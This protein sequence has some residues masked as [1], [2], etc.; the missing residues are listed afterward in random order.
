MAQ[1]ARG[2]FLQ[3]LAIQRRVIA[4]LV[5]RELYARYGRDNLGFLWLML[6]PLM[7]AAGVIVLFRG[8]RGPFENNLPVVPIVFLGYLPLLLYRHTIGRCLRCVRRNSGLLYHRQVTTLD[9]V[10]TEIVVEFA[11]NMLALVTTFTALFTL[12]LIDWPA[13]LATF[14]LGYGLM[15]WFAV[16]TALTLGALSE[17]SE[18]VERLWIPASYLYLPLSGAYPLAAWLPSDFRSLY[19]MIPSVN[20]YELIRTGYFG[21]SMES[22]GNPYYVAMWSALL[23]FM[24]LWLFR[25]VKRNLRLE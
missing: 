6:E 20:A 3:G 18:L 1:A 16:G 23:T 10:I 7:F 12:N 13:D 25:H 2:G 21:E 4:A 24:G 5:M 8:M 11:G 19:L 17:R 15:A 22:L 14:Y 9:I